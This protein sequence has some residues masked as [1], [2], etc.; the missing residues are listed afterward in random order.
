M[1]L[2]D[3]DFE[4]FPFEY[5]QESASGPHDVD[6]D[7]L[8]ARFSI[9][10]GEDPAYVE[11]IMAQFRFAIANTQGISGMKDP[12]NVAILT[13]FLLVDEINKFRMQNREEIKARKTMDQTIQD[14]I[15]RI[16]EAL[17][18]PY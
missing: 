18:T 13:V 17:E 4:N 12:L 8:G 10:V 9:T 11:E 14:L 6:F 15:T 1:I 16:D 2:P 3:S 5:Q 7:V